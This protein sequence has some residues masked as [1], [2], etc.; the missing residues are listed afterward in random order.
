MREI[1]IGQQLLIGHMPAGPHV[2]VHQRTVHVLHAL[3][4]RHRLGQHDIIVRRMRPRAKRAEHIVEMGGRAERGNADDGRSQL[5]GQHQERFLIELLHQHHIVALGIGI[6]YELALH[7][8]MLERE[9]GGAIADHIGHQCH[10]VMAHVV[11]FEDVR[12]VYGRL[13]VAPEVVVRQCNRCEVGMRVGQRI[14]GDYVQLKMDDISIVKKTACEIPVLRTC[15][16][17][18]FQEFT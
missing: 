3:P 15:L 5:M 2:F 14:T 7:V 11:H 4:E 13:Y 1:P 6:V 10:I 16:V 18:T 8:R 17:S 12:Q 9:L